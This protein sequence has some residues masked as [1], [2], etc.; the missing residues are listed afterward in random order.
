M[1]DEY[2]QRKSN[3]QNIPLEKLEGYKQFMKGQL[4]ENSKDEKKPKG[5]VSAS[6]LN[7]HM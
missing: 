7:S 4:K 3:I 5:S 2:V 1:V 6:G